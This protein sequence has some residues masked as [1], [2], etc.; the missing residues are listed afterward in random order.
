MKCIDEMLFELIPQNG[1]PLFEAAR[2]S[3][4]GGKRLRPLL[5][6]AIT[7]A[8]QIPLE[9]ALRPACALE[10][11][12]T[13][14]LIHDDL[15]CMDNDDFRRGKPSLHKTYPESHA[16]LTGD[17]LLTYA[18]EVL[19][20]APNLTDRQK[21]DLIGTLALRSGSQG[22]IGGQVL[23]IGQKELPLPARLQMHAMKTGALITAACEFGGIIALQTD[24]TPF[25]TI[26]R[27][28]GL[29]YQIV[30]DMRDQDGLIQQIGIDRADEL[31]QEH[32]EQAMET[33][34]ALPSGAIRLAQLAEE[35]LF[36]IP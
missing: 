33:I 29:A 11:V 5:T 31:A 36:R 24:L 25:Q 12:H 34:E 4:E 2:Y 20:T 22:M 21:I 8:Y 30:D 3:L 17:F 10:M 23:D 7:S 32:F 14:S 1:E 15:P 9:I 26:G 19:A 18:F 28:L 6:L 35:M 16:I 27:H 13:Y